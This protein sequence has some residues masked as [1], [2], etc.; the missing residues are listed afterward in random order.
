MFVPG[1]S[2]TSKSGALAEPPEDH[3]CNE[4]A[5]EDCRNDDDYRCDEKGPVA[6]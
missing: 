5:P 4:E 2:F 6:A 3:R 1:T